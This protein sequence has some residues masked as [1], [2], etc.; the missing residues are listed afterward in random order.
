[1]SITPEPE[2]LLAPEDVAVLF[3]VEVSTVHIWA[4][5]GRLPCTQTPTRR[6]RRFLRSD[7]VARLREAT[8]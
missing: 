1:M 7:V 6:K 5:T 8:S 4:R 2:A 3:G